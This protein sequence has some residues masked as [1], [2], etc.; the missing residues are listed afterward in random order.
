[1]FDTKSAARYLNKRYDDGYIPS[2]DR[3]VID[4]TNCLS[5]LQCEEIMGDHDDSLAMLFK[6]K[7]KSDGIKISPLDFGREFCI[8]TTRE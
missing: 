5:L 4:S 8:K 7:I 3:W 1:M 2:I 6:N